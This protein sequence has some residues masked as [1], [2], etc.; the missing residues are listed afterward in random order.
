MIV[1][2]STVS[3]QA[4]FFLAAQI[5]WQVL[6]PLHVNAIPRGQAV[7][8]SEITRTPSRP[9]VWEE[10]RPGFIACLRQTEAEA[11]KAWRQ[12]VVLSKNVEVDGSSLGKFFSANALPRKSRP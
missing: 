4:C 3:R 2:V 9:R 5:K 10:H 7:V 1:A 12:K 6:E 8:T 11:G